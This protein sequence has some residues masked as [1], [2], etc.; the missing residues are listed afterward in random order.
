MEEILSLR[1]EFDEDDIDWAVFVATVEF[2][3]THEESA[4]KVFTPPVWVIRAICITAKYERES[5]SLD[6]LNHE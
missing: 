5:S 3:K 4:C 2:A 6:W 1:E